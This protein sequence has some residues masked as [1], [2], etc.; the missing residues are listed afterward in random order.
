MEEEWSKRRTISVVFVRD[1]Q[2]ALTFAHETPP[3]IKHSHHDARSPS[4]IR[5]PSYEK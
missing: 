3:R 5:A 1:K 2:K 4:G